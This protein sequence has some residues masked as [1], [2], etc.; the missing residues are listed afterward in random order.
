MLERMVVFS[1]RESALF[2]FHL[3]FNRYARS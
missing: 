3:I 2:V 1:K